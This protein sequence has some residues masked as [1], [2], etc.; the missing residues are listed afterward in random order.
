MICYKLGCD[1]KMSS[2]RMCAM[3]Y[4]HWRRTQYKGELRSYIPVKGVVCK[5]CGEPVQARMLCARHYKAEWRK[6]NPELAKIENRKAHQAAT[7]RKQLARS[8]NLW[9]FVKNEIGIEK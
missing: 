2:R 4:Q 3:H 8:G 6:N 5:Q 7:K 1:K 9:D